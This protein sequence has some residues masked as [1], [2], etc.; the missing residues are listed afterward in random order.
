MSRAPNE[1]RPTT[2]IGI[3]VLL[4][5]TFLAC[6]LTGC[7]PAEPPRV[8]DGKGPS[9]RPNAGGPNGVLATCTKSVPVPTAA[10]NWSGGPGLR[11]SANNGA[12]TVLLPTAQGW[13]LQCDNERMFDAASLPH[14]YLLS[15]LHFEHPEGMDTAAHMATRMQGVVRSKSLDGAKCTSETLQYRS[16]KHGILDG[17]VVTSSAPSLQNT[18][19]DLQFRPASA[20]S[21]WYTSVYSTPV[22]T[23]AAS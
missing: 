5:C 21:C 19:E 9:S 22:K 8:A 2:C 1:H 15:L 17:F 12:Y 18:Q 13:K 14:R 11:I 20:V 10:A 16:A 23:N 6:A 4:S 7:E 3:W